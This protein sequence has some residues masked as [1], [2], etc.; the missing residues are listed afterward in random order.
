MKNMPQAI[1]KRYGLPVAY[2]SSHGGY[3]MLALAVRFFYAEQ[4]KKGS[5]S[6]PK[7]HTSHD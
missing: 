4:V 6:S 2:A 1:T 3:I 7:S 5:F